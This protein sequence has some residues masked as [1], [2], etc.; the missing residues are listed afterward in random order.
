MRRESAAML[1]PELTAGVTAARGSHLYSRG[2]RPTSSPLATS[3][4]IHPSHPENGER[5]RVR[6]VEGGDKETNGEEVRLVGEEE[7]RE[8]RSG[9]R[10]R[11]SNV[12]TSHC[13]KCDECP[14][15]RQLQL[16]IH[17]R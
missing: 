5:E 14:S 8:L 6:G 13:V 1:R 15:A 10:L 16:P 9:N 7:I 12:L 3:H 2:R 4:S 11:W 17:F